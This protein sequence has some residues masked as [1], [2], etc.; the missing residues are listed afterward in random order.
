MN[1]LFDGLQIAA[2]NAVVTSMGYPATWTPSDGSAAQTETVLLNKPTQKEDISDEDYAA[3][4]TKCEFLDGLF[5]GL[6][7]S[8]QAGH[9]ELINVAGVDYYAYKAD[10]KFDGKT[11]I[12][13]LE[14]KRQ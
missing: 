5:Q 7:E 1:N 8:V 2:Y 9:S 13:Q 10:R 14:P 12:L 11:I 4:T 6:F 3:V